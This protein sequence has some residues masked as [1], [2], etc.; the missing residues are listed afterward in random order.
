M[1]TMVDRQKRVIRIIKPLKNTI[2]TEQI[3]KD[4]I[5]TSLPLYFPLENK[6]QLYIGFWKDELW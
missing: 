3:F 4:I 6:I 2:L 5:Q 1:V